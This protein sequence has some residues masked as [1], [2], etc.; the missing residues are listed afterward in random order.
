M[1][2]HG[3]Q[4]LHD[5][6]GRYPPARTWIQAW[7]AEV[8]AATWTQ[9]QDIK[10]RYRTVSFVGPH[11][12][13]NVKGNDFRMATLVAYGRGIVVVEWIGTHGDYMKI[14]WESASNEGRSRQD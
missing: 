13:F 8:R 9:P 7:L 2:V 14:N 4:L 11:V 12:I 1:K 6:S 3:V 10:N 5:F